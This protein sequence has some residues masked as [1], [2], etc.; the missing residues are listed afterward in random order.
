[1]GVSKQAAASIIREKKPKAPKLKALDEA[2]G[3]DKQS[4]CL[5]VAAAC[6][7]RSLRLGEDPSAGR[8]TKEE[9]ADKAKA[10]KSVQGV[11]LLK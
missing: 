4:S 5:G 9:K 3:L 8:K 2:A 1:M 11:H 10:V 6:D 7:L